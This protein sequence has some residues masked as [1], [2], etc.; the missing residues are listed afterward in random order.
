MKNLL[1]TAA[2]LL[3]SFPLLTAAQDR[4]ITKIKLPSGQ[5]AVVAEGDFEAR[6]TG[7]F[8]VRLY[9]AASPPDETTFFTSGLIRLRDGTLEKV[10][11]ADVDGDRQP[12]I[13][14]IA[15][16]AGTGGYLSAYALTFEKDQL[17]VHA[18]VEGLSPDADP[19]AAL[20]KTKK[21][22]R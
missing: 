1:A 14:V 16:S 7:S 12:E 17:A 9:E 19:V 4:F 3:L 21:R 15:R 8:S 5:T 22:N 18:A 10:M 20:Q 2:F 11:L 6:S 13:I